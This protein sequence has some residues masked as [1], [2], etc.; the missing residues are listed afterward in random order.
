M[1]PAERRVET[2]PPVVP[3]DF[4]R[5]LLHLGQGR[6]FKRRRQKGER[7]ARHLSDLPRL[8][9]TPALRLSDRLPLRLRLFLKRDQKGGHYPVADRVGRQD[10]LRQLLLNKPGRILKHGI[11]FE[12]VRLPYSGREYNKSPPQIP[13]PAP[14]VK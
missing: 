9:L 11:S 7:L 3:L 5:R 13:A 8:R 10:L 12:T 2:V 1:L 14:A 4:G 6:I